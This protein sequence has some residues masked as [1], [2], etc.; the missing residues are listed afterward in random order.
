MSVASPPVSV[1]KFRNRIDASSR[2]TVFE[3]V[4]GNDKLLDTLRLPDTDEMR[5][6][7]NRTFAFPASAAAAS[8]QTRKD[9]KAESDRDMSS[10]ALRCPPGPLVSC[11]EF[12]DP[13][14]FYWQVMAS[15]R[16]PSS[17]AERLGARKHF[18]G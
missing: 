8:G 12:I 4:Q 16:L 15:G 11:F 1:E 7:R 2:A 18:S 3:V 5:S 10:S 13:A 17:P 14:R 6:S 9:S